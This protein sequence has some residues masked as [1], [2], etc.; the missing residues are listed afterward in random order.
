MLFIFFNQDF[1]KGTLCTSFKCAKALEYE[2][3]PPDETNMRLFVLENDWCCFYNSEHSKVKTQF[4]FP[5]ALWRWIW[6][7]NID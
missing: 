2:K 4:A 3:E 6:L 5:Y 7:L 1:L